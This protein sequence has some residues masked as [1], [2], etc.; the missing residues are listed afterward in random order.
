M[1]ELAEDVLRGDLRALARAATL[2]ENQD[3]SAAR[4][5]AES[6]HAGRALIIGITGAP[7]AGKSTL[8]DRM[9]SLLRAE[10][11]TSA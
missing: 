5:I 11:K 6:R 1:A 8:C 3:Q 2:I 4:L 10:G 9:I 7:G